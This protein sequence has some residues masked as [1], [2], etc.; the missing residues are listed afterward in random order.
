MTTCNLRFTLEISLKSSLLMEYLITWQTKEYKN[1]F[2]IAGNHFR[3]FV[4]EVSFLLWDI[5]RSFPA[6]HSSV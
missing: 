6:Y 2:P 3:T 1:E 4:F 5:S